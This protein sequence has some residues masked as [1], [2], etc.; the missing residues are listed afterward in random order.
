MT[1]HEE[2]GERVVL[3]RF[4]VTFSR[5]RLLGGL[6]SHGAFPAPPRLLTSNVVRH[7]PGGDLNQPGAR[8]VGNALPRPLQ[9]RCHQRLLNGILGGREIMETADHRAEHL[10]SEFAQ[11][12]LG[13]DL[14]WS[15][16]HSRSCYNISGGGPPGIGRT[17][18]G[19]Y[20]GA[21]PGPGAAEARAAIA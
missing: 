6:Y 13:S 2:Q 12:T 3:L 20:S 4:I 8:I 9:D 15:R 19:M 14:P 5:R 7:A 21:P 1:A 10:R 17:S 11:Q 16:G 18:I